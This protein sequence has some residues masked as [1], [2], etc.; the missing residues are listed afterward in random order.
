M[1]RPG[2]TPL[3]EELVRIAIASR[4]TVDDETFPNLLAIRFSQTL[5]LAGH[6]CFRCNI[7]GGV[8]MFDGTSPTKSAWPA[9]HKKEC[10]DG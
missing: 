3:V 1:D 9:K 8:A 7:C 10:T 4:G 2:T 6:G 5:R